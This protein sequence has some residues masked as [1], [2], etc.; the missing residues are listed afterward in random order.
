MVSR[1]LMVSLLRLVPLLLSPLSLSLPLP[2]LV[3]LVLV[4]LP[5]WL[6]VEVVVV[7]FAG[8]DDFLMMTWTGDGCL[9]IMVGRFHSKPL[10]LP[11]LGFRSSR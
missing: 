5:W 10:P 2:V 4:P 11:R 8:D 1:S 9:G 7:V 3:L 6:L